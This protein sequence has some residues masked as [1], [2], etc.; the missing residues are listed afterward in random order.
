MI[1]LLCMALLA[2][3]PQDDGGA[4]FPGLPVDHTPR[5]EIPWNRL[6]D[7]DELYAHMDRLMEAYP[8][9]VER[10]VLGRSIEN[11]ELRMYVIHDR[12]SGEDTD[13][14][15]MW[16]DGN[17][18]GNEVQ[19]SET[20]AYVAWYLVENHG[21]NP[22]I[23]AL[24]D[25]CA[26]YLAPTINPDG[27]ARWFAE[28]HTASSSRTGYLPV[29]ND[30][31]GVADEDPYNDLDGDGHITQMR[32]YVPGEG[33]H[34]LHP[35]DPRRMERVPVDERDLVGDWV[36]LGREGIDDD[37]DGRINEDGLGG[38]DMNR[39]WPSYWQP[40]HV[41]RGAGAYPLFWPETRTVARF[42]SEHPN[43]AAVQSFHNAGGMILRGPG[44]E[45]FGEYPAADVRVYDALAAEGERM[46]PFYRYM[47]IWK[48][49]Y[50]V[51]GGFVT[52][53]YEGLGIIS[54]T[55]ELWT[56][57]R[58]FPQ[59]G[60]QAPEDPHWFDDH[61]LSG[62]GFVDWHAFDHPLYG[63]IEI[64]GFK[65]DVGR[66]P[67]TFLMEE[68][69]HRNAMFCLAHAEA[70]PDVTMS[71]PVLTDLGGGTFAVDLVLRNRRL[72]PTRTTRA[73]E[74]GIGTPNLVTLHGQRVEVLAS[75]V[76]TDR[77]RPEAMEL[78]E[79]QPHRILLEEGVPSLGEVRL[80]FFVRGDGDFQV[81]YGA[82]KAR[83]VLRQGR[84]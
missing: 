50:S 19:A 44:V 79:K 77:Y 51:F 5:V 76:R 42:I 80:R 28:G 21:H 11:R 15:A 14:P 13:K 38:Y 57:Q 65:K 27:R 10:R 29:D 2:P 45:I 12:T 33:T 48:D 23:T 22:R 56:R 49:L 7:V 55:N 83:T 43:I 66:V 34:R 31:D 18:H 60:R 69:L 54:F 30:R 53:T 26:F 84:L 47:V 35:D 40:G 9:L 63:P 8:E 81:R 39:A 59:E 73:S 24:L 75:G 82:Y 25:R 68:M 4:G 17:V 71:E 6:H 67:P 37:G 1:P 70:M 16:I 52:W 41:Q 74:Q 32:K 20:V 72:I 62:A 58:S 36:L 64:G 3:L 46:L 78:T 61:L